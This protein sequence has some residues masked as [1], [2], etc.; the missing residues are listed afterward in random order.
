M[1]GF[2]QEPDRPRIQRL[3]HFKIEATLGSGGMGTIYRA[4]D[5]SMKRPVALKVLHS[6]LE[7]SERAQS[8]FVREAWIAGQLDHPNIIKVFSRGEENK[9]S[10]LALELAEGGSLSDLVEQTRESIP[11]GSDVTATVDQDYIK[12][13]LVKFIEL[14]GALEHIH[15]KGFIHRDIKP[16]NVLLSGADKKFKL[17]D[18]GI[19]H[20]EDMT[21]MTQA[22]D[23]IGTVRYMSPEL[24]A[25][26]RA[27]IDKRTDIYSLGVTLYEALTLTL[28]FKAD[29][30]EKLIGEI[31]AG[32]CIE[33][34][35]ANRRIPVDLET[36][37]M[38][39]CH[40]DPDLRY[41]T[42]AEFADDLQRITDGRPVLARRQSVV[43]KGVKYVRRN[44][45]TVLGLAAAVVVLVSV[46][47]WSYY[48]V[49][50]AYRGKADEST[51]RE[52]GAKPTFTKIDVPG[53]PGY[54]ALSP[55]GEKLAFMSDDGGLWVVPTRG[56][57]DPGVVG[58]PAKLAQVEISFRAASLPVW[59]ADGKWIA[60]NAR[61]TVDPTPNRWFSMFVIPSTG[62]ELREVPVKHDGS[63]SWYS[64][65][66]SLSPDGQ[67]IAFSADT[68]LIPG[69][70]ETGCIYSIP[71]V[72][73]QIRRLTDTL[74]SMPAFSPDG[75]MLAYVQECPPPTKDEDWHS[76]VW[77]VPVDGGTP[78]QVSDSPGW[79]KG[80][81]WSPDSRMIAF[82]RFREAGFEGNELFIV[83]L[84][85]DYKPAA[86]PTIIELPL[87]SFW[88]MIA[89]WS[90]SNEIGIALRTTGRSAVYT[91]PVSGGIA[92]QVA[93]TGASSAMWF[94]D[95]KRVLFQADG[96]FSIPAEGGVASLIPITGVE[97]TR[98]ADVSYDGRR[99]ILA[100]VD[101]ERSKEGL[102]TASVDG[103]EV[104]LIQYVTSYYRGYGAT[105][106]SL[107]GKWI[108]V[109]SWNHFGLG[110]LCVIPSDGGELRQLVASTD[111][112]RM[113][114]I[115]RPA[116]SPDGKLIA[117][118]A[119]D[120]EGTGTICAIP[121]E[122]GDPEI[123]VKFERGDAS[124]CVTW[125]PDGKK[126]AY[127]S[128]RVRHR[129][130]V[131]TSFGEK[132]DIWILSLDVK[133]PVRLKTGLGLK[134]VS[135]ID[136]SPDGKKIVFSAYWAGGSDFHFV[137]NFLPLSQ[138]AEQEPLG[139]PES[140]EMT[141]R[142]V[143]SGEDV[144]GTGMVSSDGAFLPFID[145]ASGNL[146]LRWLDDGE[147]RYLTDNAFFS[148]V[149]GDP[150]Q[151]AD[152]PI[153]SPDGKLIAY[154][155][156]TC[157]TDASG[158]D[159]W[160]GDLCLI[161]PDGTNRRVLLDCTHNVE[162]YP[163]SFSPGGSQIAVSYYDST[164]WQIALVST[165]DG[166]VRT[167]K[168]LGNRKMRGLSFSTD[169]R[170]LAYSL[171]VE[172]PP[173]N[174]DIFLLAVDGSGEAPLVQHPAD[175]RLLGWVPGSHSAMFVSNRSGDWDAWLIQ[176]KD[177]QPAGEPRM[178]KR[179]MGNV[180]P[181]GFTRDSS[182]YYDA[183]I[184]W[185]IAGVGRIDSLTGKL[186]TPLEEPVAGWAGALS[187][188]PDGERAV[189]VSK[190]VAPA[191]PGGTRAVINVREL[192][193]GRQ[194]QVSC[195]TERVRNRVHWSPDGRCLL[196]RGMAAKA[197]LGST[198]P[199]SLGMTDI[200]SNNDTLLVEDIS[201][202]RMGGVW[203]VDGSSIYYVDQ[204][205]LLRF[206]LATGQKTLVYSEFGLQT[207]LS[208]S[209]NGEQMLISAPRD[210]RHCILVLS[211]SSGD[212]RVLFRNTINDVS[213]KWWTFEWMPN[214]QDILFT[215][216]EGDRMG[217]SSLWRISAEGGT[218]EN[219]LQIPE[220]VTELSI[221][222]NGRQ[223]SVTSV[224]RGEE[225]WVM[226]NFLLD[227]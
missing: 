173:T 47:I 210:G 111:S 24:L 166:S 54:C 16:Q 99:L 70:S 174:M 148:K 182:F 21:R 26:H 189:Y 72:G 28:P 82:D 194:H 158:G 77:V 205:S 109:T 159:F 165:T 220:T 162:A 168:K 124:T 86:S 153:P 183:L 169:G 27:G 129:A 25:A 80:P 163:M 39:A 192:G 131:G 22:G 117:Y 193:T 186:A 42:A 175:D 123:V 33:A 120:D 121:L 71:V 75:K 61:D 56:A 107:D 225:I 119:V 145:W 223:I 114:Y 52:V 196:Y 227:D 161:N 44:Y 40:H 9:V 222:P 136:W 201:W 224:K 78:I 209:P 6:S 134:E 83:P 137:E 203:S 179:N 67:T 91:V 216:L 66:L 140:K 200:E 45:K 151:Y 81:V 65:R 10:Y 15:S 219:I 17:T 177:G 130:G 90:S 132:A 155:W 139:D 55:D 30:E 178:V 29:S 160:S 125:S 64:Y 101:K 68:S 221:H 13:I 98:G 150:D 171:S 79:M 142:M 3:G 57:A 89:G 198:L 12:D 76:D 180:I 11:S 37:L 93:P 172:G 113:P 92:T 53:F 197:L 87:P 100:A 164:G 73:E 74:C 202:G 108:A 97:W 154:T 95:G 156:Y 147:I 96:V 49:E 207:W 157:C 1:G 127:A 18:F 46:I 51:Q 144:D 199:Y 106:W 128:G 23:F 69:E 206:D 36:V 146:A 122:G 115:S 149:R 41:Q 19:A 138:P 88:S 191:L 213:Q 4:Y 187:W 133:E 102:F 118:T 176:V 48:K 14:A 184:S 143:W 35:K 211:I 105:S 31:L 204:D 110:D 188:S 5:E 112:S 181:L 215:I 104:E 152:S 214:G 141:V 195:R 20:A 170:Y 2:D 32:H 50:Q 103:G 38:K 7:I 116:W 212:T 63:S 43:S 58:K 135:D 190:Q 208:L 85:E 59:S 94:P 217:A 126:L 226:Q 34:R 84:T 8:R 218:A 60:F 167:L 185:E 62:G